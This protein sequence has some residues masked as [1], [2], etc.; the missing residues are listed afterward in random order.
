MINQSNIPGYTQLQGRGPVPKS[1]FVTSDGYVP[2]Y[3][4]SNPVIN[5]ALYMPTN[6]SGV[7]LAGNE[8]NT[9]RR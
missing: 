3:L 5:E 1:N 4:S 9:S 7:G 8:S 6:K 2:S